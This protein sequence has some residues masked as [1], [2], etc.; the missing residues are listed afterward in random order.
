MNKSVASSKYTMPNLDE[1][2]DTNY[3]KNI[4]SDLNKNNINKIPT[5]VDPP[6]KYNSQYPKVI[7]TIN[8]LF[9]TVTLLILFS[10]ITILVASITPAPLNLA[11][12]L[13]CMTPISTCVIK[14]IH[15]LLTHKGA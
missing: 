5:H 1:Y 4:Y 2:Y 7:V 12:V 13:L 8:V 11:L 6:K 3:Q 10:L 15:V 9:L 14:I